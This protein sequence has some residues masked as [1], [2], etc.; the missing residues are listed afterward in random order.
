MSRVYIN[1]VHDFS[2]DG[3]NLSFSLT[4]S[5][6]SKTGEIRKTVSFQCIS[7][8]QVIEDIC[9]YIIKEIDTIKSMTKDIE[10]EAKV[11]NKISKDK[12]NNLNLGRKIDSV[13][14]SHI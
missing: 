2:Y 13:D 5:H 3:K 7:E 12:N 1:G 9:K 8:I 14:M 6:Q 11:D 10:K 4:D